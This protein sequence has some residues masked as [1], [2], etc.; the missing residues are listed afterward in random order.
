MA[1]KTKDFRVDITI[2]HVPKKA[3]VLV[4]DLETGGV[5]AFKANLGFILN[6]GYKWLGESKTHVL[7]V[8]DYPDWFK[9]TRDLPINDKPLLRDALKI[10]EEAD[11]LVAHYGE[12]FDRRFFQ[13]RCVIHNLKPPPPIKLRDTWRIARS[14]FAF[15]S[16]RLGVLAQVLRLGEKKHQKT[17]R[18][19][20][21]WW[22][23]AMAG[24]ETAIQ[25]MSKY[26]AQ[27]VRTT[28]ALYLRT[29]VYDNLNHPRLFM[30][31]DNCGL[32]GA[33][34]NYHGTTMVGTHRYKRYQ[35]TS[36]GRW[37]RERRHCD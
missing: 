13:G 22:F 5:N 25:Q 33:S 7:R 26:C 31:R 1:K 6:F 28:E 15:Q 27:D 21:G 19:W 17:S 10:M 14:A 32:C 20:P 16:N 36:C 18:E 30:N 24:D 8:S 37:D 23:R 4:W 2:R 29:R 3:K 35:C 34:V 9:K 11:I 12:R